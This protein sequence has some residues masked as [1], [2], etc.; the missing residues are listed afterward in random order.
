ML[1]AEPDWDA[2]PNDLPANVRAVLR[3]CLQKD[4]NLRYHD[5]ADVR[6]ELDES[7]SATAAAVQRPIR[8]RRIPALP[9]IL[10]F[11][12]TA[13]LIA[14]IVL[15]GLRHP[16]PSGSVR[17]FS[18]PIGPAKSLLITSLAISPDGTELAYTIDGRLFRRSM[19]ESGPGSAGEYASERST[20]V[21]S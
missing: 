12:S 10:A 15:T 14:L 20:H 21:F 2:L 3:R 19:N 1:K 16:T 13:V 7:A 6:I 17:R 5:I 11:L 8:V 18:I 9:W 4:R